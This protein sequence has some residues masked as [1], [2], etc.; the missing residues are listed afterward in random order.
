MLRAR[1]IAKAPL[2]GIIG[3][4]GEAVMRM[5]RPWACIIGKAAGRRQ[6][7]GAGDHKSV[8]AISGAGIG[9]NLLCDLGDLRGLCP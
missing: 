2:S 8:V 7:R 9:S 6:A 1:R 4:A 3:S 5:D